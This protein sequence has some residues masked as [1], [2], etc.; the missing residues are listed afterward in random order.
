M[1]RFAFPLLCSIF[2]LTVFSAQAS[3]QDW[4]QAKLKQSS[5][6]REWATVKHDSRSVQTFVVYPE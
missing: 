1:K 3:A 6:H 5:R 4:A 2:A